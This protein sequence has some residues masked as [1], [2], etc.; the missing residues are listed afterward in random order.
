MNYKHAC[1][2]DA[3]GIYVT[4]V[5]VLKEMSEDGTE[6]STIQHYTLKDG[7]TLVDA[8]PPIYR[9]HAGTMGFIAPKWNGVRW[10]ESATSDAI[11]E[12]EAENPDPSKLDIVSLKAAK[13]EEVNRDCTATIHAGAEVE[14][15]SGTER[16]SFK[17]EDQINLKAA[18][19]EVKA[20][21]AGYPYHAD[22]Q[23][24][25]IYSAADIVAIATALAQHKLYHT[26]Y[27]NHL[28][29]WIRRAVDSAELES[30]VYGVD[31]PA[32]LAANMQ[33]VLA[34][35]QNII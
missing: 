4:L 20:G 27:A 16:F 13:L 23:L 21:A 14:L 30:I 8:T 9:Y 10:V 31:L 3:N 35:A 15:S 32:D 33:G 18:I 34:D 26:T 12:W 1:V 24:C 7:E 11:A 29:V 2:I 17:A 5:L 19:D 22:G 25:R 28:N 6:Q